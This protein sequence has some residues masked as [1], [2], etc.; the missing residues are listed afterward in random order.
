MIDSKR[1]RALIVAFVAV[2][3]LGIL[4]KLESQKIKN[5]IHSESLSKHSLSSGF[6]TNSTNVSPEKALEQKPADTSA[7]HS[8][9]I[10]SEDSFDELIES[11]EK[12]LARVDDLR[13]LS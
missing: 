11:T 5:D 10:P 4:H 3:G 8:S 7:T 9:S 1:V 6:K 13:K 2:S 12:V